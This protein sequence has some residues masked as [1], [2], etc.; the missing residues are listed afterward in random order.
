[1]PINDE[2][3]RN[4]R[5]ILSRNKADM[6]MLTHD[7]RVLETA[8]SQLATSVESGIGERIQEI[9]LYLK[10]LRDSIAQATEKYDSILMQEIGP[11]RME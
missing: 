3:V 11:Y 7:I 6:S 5:A 9:I 4:L 2:K 1:M 8:S 10:R